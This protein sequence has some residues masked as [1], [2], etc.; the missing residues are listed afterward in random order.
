MN[1]SAS[2]ELEAGS[3]E[4]LPTLD[5]IE[6]RILGCLLEKQATTRMPIR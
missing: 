5:A 2:T 3:A 6:A 1:D 4:V